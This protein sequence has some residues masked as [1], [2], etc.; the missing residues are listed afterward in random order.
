MKKIPQT[1]LDQWIAAFIGLA[2]GE[3]LTPERLARYQLVRLNRTL[4][5]A[6][7]HNPFYRQLWGEDTPPRLSSLED[8]HTLPFTSA[9]DLQQAPNRLLSVSQSEVARVVTLNSSGTTGTP[10]RVFFSDTDLERTIDFFHHGMATLVRPGQRVLILLPGER[11]G[12]VGDLLRK[13]LARMDVTGVIH[14]PVEDP[15]AVIDGM[16]EGGIDSLVGTPT[17]VLALARHK[18]S[19]RIPSGAVKSV[20]LST[21]YVPLAVVAAIQRQWGCAVFQHYGM[22]EMGFGGGVACAAHEGYHLREA[23]L[24]F[25]I[26]DPATLRPVGPGCVGE[27]VFTTLTRHAMP[28]IRYR[29]GD[30]A[31]WIAAPCPCG[32]AL[33]RMGW[34]RG[35]RREKVRMADGTPL[36]LAGLDEALFSLPEVIDFQAAVRRDSGRLQLTLKTKETGADLLPRTVA[37]LEKVP[38]VRE[39]LTRGAL[40]IGPIDIESGSNLAGSAAKRKLR[41]FP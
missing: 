20:L 31:T 35:R 30:L 11:P 39:A 25:E 32:S 26:I 1:P 33:R 37:A 12:S 16:I 9:E 14:G 27:V 22:T 6:A 2:A 5:R 29:T 17:Q 3:R 4:A 19:A 36:D 10:K 8:L 21:D 41:S 24:L 15:A 23:D 18:Q 34:V 40:R 13:G 38:A 28:L 7:R